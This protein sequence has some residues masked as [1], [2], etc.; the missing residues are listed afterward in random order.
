M[1]TI[2][3]GRIIA[4]GQV[5]AA[6]IVPDHHVANAPFVPILRMRLDQIWSMLRRPGIFL[7]SLLAREY[8][9]GEKGGSGAASS[10]LV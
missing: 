10:P 2:L 6:A 5:V 3:F 9:L 1:D 8:A 7:G 4:G